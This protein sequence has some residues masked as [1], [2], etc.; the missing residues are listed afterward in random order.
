MGAAAVRVADGGVFTGVGLDK[1][2]G[3]VALCQETGAFVQA[4]TRDRDVVASVCA[5]RDLEHGRVL[6][7][8]PWGI[9]QE[10][11]ALWAPGS[12]WRP[13]ARTTR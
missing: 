5:C 2:H 6:I 1:L 10:W 11:L 7:L 8:P 13:R 12:K 9:S 3:A 4:Y